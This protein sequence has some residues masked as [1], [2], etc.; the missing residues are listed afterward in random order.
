MAICL[1]FII[2]TNWFREI[3]FK[4]LTYIC[5]LSLF[6]FT[7]LPTYGLPLFTADIQVDG[8][9]LFENSSFRYASIFIAPGLASYYFVSLFAYHLIDSLFLKKNFESI[10][11]TLLIFICGIFTINRSFIICVSILIF[12]LIIYSFHHTI[13]KAFKYIFILS[14]LIIFSLYYFQSEIFTNLFFLYIDRFT[15]STLIENRISG[16][17]G[18][19]ESII[20]FIQHPAIFGRLFY[21]GN[22]FFI[23]DSIGNTQQPHFS[24]AY[25]LLGFGPIIFFL[26]I[27]LY[28]FAF[29]YS[30]FMLYF[31]KSF[32]NRYNYKLLIQMIFLY[33]GLLLVSLTEVFLLETMNIIVL[34]TIFS[35]Y[36]NEKY[37]YNSR[38]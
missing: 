23:S 3:Y 26:I 7:F 33:I 9:D 30:F 12:L 8:Q 27:L 31:K 1:S 38:F 2:N 22:S 24:Y 18:F 10:I 21:D 36:I 15:N 14:I 5:V 32:S 29:M 11:L 13:L 37:D 17:T 4:Q 20:D 16:D 34:F 25:Y 6:I 28:F 35:I 19:I